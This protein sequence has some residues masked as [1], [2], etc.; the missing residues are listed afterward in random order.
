ME[1][2]GEGGPWGMA[3]L[4]AYLT[5]R[6]P[7]ESLD[8]YL[9]NEVF[10]QAERTSVTAGPEAVAGFASFLERYRRCLPVERAAVDTL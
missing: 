9:S 7:D 10:L 3:I 2:A 6:K 5:N 1:T 4:A 8:A